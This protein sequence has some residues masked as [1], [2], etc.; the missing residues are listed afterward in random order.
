MI[1]QDLCGKMEILLLST[2][3]ICQESHHNDDG[4]DEDDGYYDEEDDLCYDDDNDHEDFL[5]LNFS[6]LSSGSD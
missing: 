5:G 4:H 2:Y 1:W 6:H 3:P